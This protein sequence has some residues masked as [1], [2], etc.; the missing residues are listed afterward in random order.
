MKKIFTVAAALLACYVSFACTTVIVGAGASAN[1]RPMMWKHRDSSVAFNYVSHF[2]GNGYAFTGVVNTADSTR[3]SVWCG[4][5]EVGFSVM[6]S[7]SYGLSPLRD[8]ERPWEGIIM[9]KALETCATVDEFEAYIASL[10]QP[11]GLE[12]NF[13][14]IDAKGG[15]AYFEV[16]DFGYKRFDVPHDGYLIRSNYSMTGRKGEG[17]GYDRYDLVEG[18]MKAHGAP[19]TAEWILS[20]LARDPLISRKT[21]LSSVVMEGIGEGEDPAS[22]VLWCATGYARFCYALPVWVA[23]GEMIPEP[24]ALTEGVGSTANVLAEELKVERRDTPSEAATQ[25]AVQLAEDYEF[26]EGRSMDDNFRVNGW[27]DYRTSEYNKKAAER[28]K[29]FRAALKS[30]R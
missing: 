11:N 20:D 24:L 19:F 28:F 3:A 18:K 17:K 21:S 2:S 16:H 26:A 14:V 4:S 30:H 6:N 8:Q 22:G 27:C 15:A 10:P 29:I 7:V 25:A 23:A 1:G 12:A 9:K 5:N 13:G